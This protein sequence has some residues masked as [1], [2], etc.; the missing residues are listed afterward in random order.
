MYNHEYKVS[1]LG[2]DR[3]ELHVVQADDQGSFWNTG[4]AQQALTRVQQLSATQNTLVVLFIHGWH[5]NAAPDDDNLMAFE[6]ALDDLYTELAR[7]DR[8]T[9]RSKV[10]NQPS[11]KI[12]GIYV[13]W[14]GRSLPGLLD[15]LTFWGRKP[16]AERVGAGDL[17]EFIE[18]LQEIYLK[19]NAKGG[20]DQPFTGL[21]TIG[22]SFGG[23]VLWKSLARQLETPLAAAAPC[24]SN[25]LLPSTSG[26]DQRT[27]LPDPIGTLGDLNILVN[28]ALEA[29]QFARVDALYR[30]LQYPKEQTPQVLVVS[31][32]NDKARAFYFPLARG[33]T[34]LFR[35]TLR[36]D[37]DSYQGTLYG[38]ALGEVP[39][40][41]TH[42]LNRTPAVPDTYTEEIYR[43]EERLI[44]AD[45]TEPTTFG[46]ITLAPAL[47]NRDPQA[48]ARTPYSPVLVVDAHDK[49]VDGHNGLFGDEGRDFR[50]FLTKYIAYVEGKRLV[51]R[52]GHQLN[53]R[54]ANPVAVAAS[55]PAKSCP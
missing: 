33:A 17:S 49:I 35:P 15:Y 23:Q 19:A 25:S 48:P 52:A 37:N 16:T 36:P 32:D 54:N 5:H 30:Q 12:V 21:V 40:Q 34:W 44:S 38:K 20:R 45:F 29:Y 42:D 31:S 27:G 46:G 8:V 10:T 4:V 22:H 28:P 13:G 39:A 18:R 3:Y 9:L 47:V 55:A 6:Q 51:L 11:A 41:K 43:H 1:P 50:S 2:T 26:T 24:M 7:P 53:L 14:R